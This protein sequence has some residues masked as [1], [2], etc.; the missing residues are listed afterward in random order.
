MT[1][2]PDLP[3]LDPLARKIA[4]EMGREPGAQMLRPEFLGQLA[5]RATLAAAAFVGDPLA[6]ATAMAP[7]IRAALEELPEVCRYHGT[8]LEPTG[9]WMSRREACCDTGLP[10]LRRRDAMDALDRIGGHHG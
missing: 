8:N 4:A 9:G 1:D 6:D 2:D 3:E 7:V 10:A 5:A